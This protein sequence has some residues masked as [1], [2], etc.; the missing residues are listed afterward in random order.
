MKHLFLLVLICFVAACAAKIT[1]QESTQAPGEYI[2]GLSVF[3]S[4][5][6]MVDDK[7]KPVTGLVYVYSS[8]RL[9]TLSAYVDGI[10]DGQSVAYHR[11]GGLKSV[12]PYKKG[13][14]DGIARLYYYTGEL[15]GEG[16]YKDGAPAAPFTYYYKNGQVKEIE[17]HLYDRTKG[18][19]SYYPSG[20]LAG[21]SRL[22]A[23]GSE[24]EKRF[25]PDGSLLAELTNIDGILDSGLCISPSGAKLQMTEQD[26]EDFIYTGELSCQ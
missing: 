1:P 13:K 9:R 11:N 12:I 26:M 4:G 8:G 23:D 20:A 3:T 6:L 19:V 10:K 24:L 18:N 21:E 25:R 14:W 17:H 22:L 2:H 15:S 5:D 7:G 16:A